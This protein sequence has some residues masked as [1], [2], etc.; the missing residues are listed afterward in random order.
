MKLMKQ[1][2]SLL[3]NNR[4]Q[5]RTRIFSSNSK[6]RPTIHQ[7]LQA[8]LNTQIQAEFDAC[9]AYLSMSTYFGRSSVALPGC[10][11]Y[12]MKMHNEEH[13]HALLFTKYQNLRGGKVVLCPVNV[14]EISDW[15]IKT[16]FEVALEMEKCV[17][18]KL[19]DVIGVAEEVC[20]VSAMDI[21]TAQFLNDQDLS[22][23]ELSRILTQ[24]C[25]MAETEI[26]KY[27][28]DRLIFKSYVDKKTPGTLRDVKNVY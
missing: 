4:S 27:F 9:F 11:N 12:F 26:G 6:D 22:I 18:K 17:K 14:P 25:Y 28:F 20:D 10:E 1:I 2:T 5:L 24:Y 3:Y 19:L 7:K 8:A 21:I 13:E 15:T 16:A 23:D